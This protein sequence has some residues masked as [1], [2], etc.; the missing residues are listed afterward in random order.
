MHE[1]S[2]TL[3]KGNHKKQITNKIEQK[4]SNNNPVY[5]LKAKRSEI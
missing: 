1:N 2:K 4:M 3:E 5:N